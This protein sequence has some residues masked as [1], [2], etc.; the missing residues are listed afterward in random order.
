M[1]D[2]YEQS[3]ITDK[4]GFI[5][6]ESSTKGP[7]LF[8]HEEND[9]RKHLNY[10]SKHVAKKKLVIV[11]HTPPFKILD[12][13]IRF[14]SNEEGTH[15]IGSE[16]L[17]E[18]MDNN[19][20]A[21]IICGHCH[22]NGGRYET[23]NNTV[24]ANV[25]SHDNPGAFGNICVI[26]LTSEDTRIDFHSTDEL[27]DVSSPRKIH[28]IGPHY[29]DKLEKC[30]I[31]TIEQLANI[32]NIASV[33]SISG[34]SIKH[35]ST[36]KAKA[37]SMLN[38]QVMQLSPFIN[39]VFKPIYFDIETDVKCERVW[40]IGYLIDEKFTQLFAKNWDHEK[41]IL[42]QFL[43]M[44]KQNPQR[45]LI[46]YSGTNFDSR[47]VYNAL[48]RQNLDANFFRIYTHIDLATHLKRAFIFPNQSYAL[49]ELGSYLDYPF[50]HS[51]MDGLDVAMSYHSHIENGT[52]LPQNVFEYNEDDVRAIPYLM[53]LAFSLNKTAQKVIY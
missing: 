3:L 52:E 51:D 6:L 15:N 23:V 13:G 47:V 48:Q 32:E 8:R 20:V 26:E 25:S 37:Q 44:L 41:R 42:T 30:E 34:F 12:R 22:S 1:S 31:K 50:K 40:M 18:Y 38:S 27:I 33:S 46:S 29:C 11:S 43:E 17:R 39:P 35:L 5:G 9:F 45:G 21:L 7:A 4:F 2:L 36:L 16:A 49:K 24:I 14:A 19:D 10:Q 28:G 53:D